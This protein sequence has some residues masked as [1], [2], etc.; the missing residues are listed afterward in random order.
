MVF[1]SYAIWP[2][3]TV[4]ANVGFPLKVTR[5][6]I[7]KEQ[8]D[9]Q[10]T[11]ALELVQLAQ[12]GDRMSTELSGGQQQRV[13]LARALVRRPKVLL[14]DEPLSNLDAELRERMR[15]EI[16]EVQQRLGIT[17]VFVTHDQ[18][19]ALA[20]SDK[21]IV[22]NGGRIVESGPPQ[23]IYRAPMHS[24]TAQFIG[25]SNT[26]TA[27]VTSRAGDLLTVATAH[28]E[29]TAQPRAGVAI[30]DEVLVAVRPEAFALHR[31]NGPGG[32]Q[33]VVKV[34][35]Y[36]G[37]GWIY[38]VDLGGQVLRVHSKGADLGLRTGDPVTVVPEHGAAIVTLDADPEAP[39]R[40][41]AARPGFVEK[42][43]VVTT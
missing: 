12:L 40:S 34:G 1:Q 7:R 30:G 2:H 9:G 32:W 29:L 35:I 16:R 6:R 26:F 27:R 21:I 42:E 22:M 31:G 33:G 18:S 20:M 39:P 15:D 23:Q 24:F 25:A 5:P 4:R 11:E 3:M 43:E 37:E 28:G 10:V 8:I 41:G 36:S 17:T 13:A 19:E 38:Q 14:L